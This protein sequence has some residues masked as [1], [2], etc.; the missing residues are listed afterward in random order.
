MRTLKKIMTVYHMNKRESK[1]YLKEIRRLPTTK[2]LL[3]LYLIDLYYN[4][5]EAWI[6]F[7]HI[8]KNAAIN[9]EK[10]AE[11]IDNILTRR[12]L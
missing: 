7:G 11:R 10:L 6:S 2:R 8:V 1:K 5:S 3:Q 12:G 9:F 4:S